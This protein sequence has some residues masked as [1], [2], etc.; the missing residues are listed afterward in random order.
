MHAPVILP[1]LTRVKVLFGRLFYLPVA[2]LHGSLLL[3]L[4]GGLHDP[5]WLRIGAIGNVAAI[6]L[7]ALTMAGAAWAWRARHSSQSLLRHGH[8]SCP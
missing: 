5:F 1:A 8:A 3:R 4:V 2:V 7:F 6:V